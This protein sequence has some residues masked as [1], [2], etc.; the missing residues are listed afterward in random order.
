MIVETRNYGADDGQLPGRTIDTRVDDDNFTGGIDAYS[1]SLA[2]AWGKVRVG[3]TVSWIDADMDQRYLVRETYFETATHPQETLLNGK[4][5]FS[6]VQFDLGLQWQ[7]FDTITFGLVYHSGFETDL[8][9]QERLDL[10]CDPDVWGPACGVPSE[11][12]HESSLKWPDGWTVGAK[13]QPTSRWVVA[14][15]YGQTEWSEAR[16]RGRQFPSWDENGNPIVVDLGTVAYPFAQEQVDTWAARFGAEYTLNYLTA[17]IPV[18]VGYIREQQAAL[19]TDFTRD[20]FPPDPQSHQGV[21]LGVGIIYEALQL[22][23]AWAHMEGEHDYPITVVTE[24]DLFRVSQ[25]TDF[26]SDRFLASLSYKF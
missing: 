26:S 5:Q 25:R 10:S 18:R 19:S 24:D 20:E 15:D 17:Q 8:D 9:S 22:D 4:Y 3:L 23:L 14:V 2:S 11:L 12:R 13:W 21:T 6:D 7:A 1:A 16:V